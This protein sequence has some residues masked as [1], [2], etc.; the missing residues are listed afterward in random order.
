MVCHCNN[1]RK[2]SGSAFGQS[3]YF[4]EDNLVSIE[5]SFNSYVVENERGTQTRY[6]CKKCGTNLYWRTESLPDM[7]GVAGG[8]FVEDPLPIPGFTTW[9][10]DMRPWLSLSDAISTRITKKE[11][12]QL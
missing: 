10:G 1:C 5:G 7:V 11:L 2:K 12:P 3:S 6:F 4:K 9:H 8:C